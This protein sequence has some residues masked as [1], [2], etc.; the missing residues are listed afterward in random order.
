MTRFRH[1]YL[2]LFHSIWDSLRCSLIF[3][4][5]T[6]IKRQFYRK[7]SIV[8]LISEGHRFMTYFVSRTKVGSKEVGE[9][10]QLL[11]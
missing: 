6:T 2:Y 7:K 8:S 4:S 10:N 9:W 5:R 11:Q 1:R 3:R